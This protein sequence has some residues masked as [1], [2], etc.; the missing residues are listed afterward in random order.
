MNG[1]VRP[2]R[3]SGFL[4]LKVINSGIALLRNSQNKTNSTGILTTCKRV[5]NLEFRLSIYRLPADV[6]NRITISNTG[7]A[8]NSRKRGGIVVVS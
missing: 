3:I 1:A 8:I 7:G 5:R 2:E 6:R 4:P